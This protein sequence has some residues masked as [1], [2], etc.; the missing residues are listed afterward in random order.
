ML[1]RRKN[2]TLSEYF[3]SGQ[4][5][6]VRMDE[7]CRISHSPVITDYYHEPVIQQLRC[8]GS[9]VLCMYNHRVRTGHISY[10]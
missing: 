5:C 1:Q 4:L 6:T 3:D 7:E 8:K 10:V 2:V 9:A